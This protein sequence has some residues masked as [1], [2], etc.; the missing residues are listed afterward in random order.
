MKKVLALFALMA[1]VSCALA[2]SPCQTGVD[3]GT[4]SPWIVCRV[5]PSNTWISANS[6]G[7]FH[8]DLICKNLGFSGMG[9][10]GGTCGSVCGFCEE[11]TTTSC[12]ILGTETYDHGT[13][14]ANCG[15][16]N[17]GPI[18]C[19]TVC[20][21]CLG[22]SQIAVSDII[23]NVTSATVST[24]AGKVAVKKT[25]SMLKSFNGAVSSGNCMR[26]TLVAEV[27]KIRL[28]QLKVAGVINQTTLDGYLNDID[29]IV[30][31]SCAPP[32]PV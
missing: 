24:K 13:N 1:S 30:A 32:V 21:E 14:T 22:Q 23:S 4:G 7:N 28:V 25:L 15:S 27:V 10:W 19:S 20:W 31:S 3:P 16:D 26:I 18:I 12:T 6:S 9:R 8:A 5:T 2:I 11:G 29:A 17:L